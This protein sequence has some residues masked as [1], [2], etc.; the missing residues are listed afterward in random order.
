MNVD[1]PAVSAFG[2]RGLGR[3]P[4]PPVRGAQPAPP[5]GSSALL[6]IVLVL[7]AMIVAG[8]VR[9]L[10][11]V[12]TLNTKTAEAT[13]Q[14]IEIVNQPVTHLPRTAEAGVFSPG[15]FHP[16]ALKPDFS[17]VDVRTSQEF[18]YA[19]YTYVTSDI[20][21]SEMFIGEELEFNAMT[22]Y[23]YADRTVPKKKL[24]APEMVRINDLYRLIGHDDEAL[25][26]RWLT[27]AALTLIGCVLGRAFISLFGRARRSAVG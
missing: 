12:D 15:W 27:L 14:V 3:A 26:V 22:K 17:R 8:V 13:R 6:T 19:G 24:S 11:Q 7:L 2:R 23:F 20:D 1:D 16:G 10:L 9:T 18:P 25:D 21:P 5:A 4:A